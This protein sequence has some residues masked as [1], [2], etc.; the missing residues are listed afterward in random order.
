M[1]ITVDTEDIVREL[2]KQVRGINIL[3]VTESD[4]GYEEFIGFL[5]T[6]SIVMG[7]DISHDLDGEYI[8]SITVNGE[9]YATP[10]R[11]A[12]IPTGDIGDRHDKIHY[13]ESSY[14]EAEHE[15]MGDIQRF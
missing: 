3:G 7:I 5:H 12:I 13:K 4:I 2:L 10:E 9:E 6:G 15:W 14:E 8:N 11:G 1:K